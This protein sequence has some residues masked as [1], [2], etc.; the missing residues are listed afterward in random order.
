MLVPVPCQVPVKEDNEESRKA[1]GSLHSE[2]TPNTESGEI[3]A[4]S[5]E[6]K[7]EG[8]ADILSPYGKKRAASESWEV[9]APKRGKTPLSGGSGS[10]GDVVAHFLRKDK[11]PAES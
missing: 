6:H 5:S 3:K 10:E 1:K 2:G 9:R 7:K 11:P 4:P 8:E